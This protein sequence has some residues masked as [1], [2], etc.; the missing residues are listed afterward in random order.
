MKHLKILLALLFFTSL[1]HAQVGDD[2][3]GKYHLPNDLDIEIYKEG[4]KYFGKII[5]LNGYQNGQTTDTK[6]PDDS[7]HSTPLLGMLII[8]GLEFDMDE[9]Q[10]INGKMY[11]PEKGM[12]FNLKI[13]EIREKDIE[14]VGSKYFFWHTL[15]WLKI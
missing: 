4:N 9:K 7:E 6:N 2:I 5:A 13:T 11:G 3:I 12:I 10:W 14:V 1:A 15:E 8:H